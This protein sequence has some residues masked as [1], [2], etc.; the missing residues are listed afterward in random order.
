M[1]VD[2]SYRVTF[3]SI[4]CE[5]V[6]VHEARAAQD[7]FHFNAAVVFAQ[8]ANEIELAVGAGREV[9]MASF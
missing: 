9:R 1:R 4:V 2:A 3:P 7:L 5:T 8:H 6:Q